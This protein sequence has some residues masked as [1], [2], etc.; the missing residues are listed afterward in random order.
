MA[1]STPTTCLTVQAS[2]R[3][4][5]VVNG[6]LPVVPASTEKLLTATAV[7]DQ[8]GP[9]ATVTTRAVAASG[10]TDGVV[11][12][13]LYVIGAGDP[14]LATK[15]YTST[16]EEP[17]EPYNDFAGL[18]DAL[19]SAGVTQI[20]GDVV[21]DESYFDTQRYLPSWP[22]RYISHNEVGPLGALMVNDGFTGLS[23]TP[24]VPA[25]NRR[26]G[27][28]AQLSAATLIS[29]LRERGIQVTGGPSV[30]TAPG[31]AVTVASLDS[32]PMSTNVSEM[33][34]RSDNTTA[35][36][37]AKLLGAHAGSGGTTEA[38][39]AVVHQSLQDL[40]FPL[41]G[42][43]EVDGSGLDL[44]NRVTCDLLVAALDHQG[45]DSTLA[46]DLPVAGRSGTLRKRLRGTVAE[47]DV[48]AKT[49][50]L[51]DVV[52]LA[53]FAKAADGE[54]LTFA[55]VMNGTLPANALTLSDDVAVAVAQYGTGIS[56]DQLG[57]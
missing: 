43:V 20:R 35:E 1:Q 5:A 27:D 24:E 41:D 45:P 13:N 46:G 19:K 32:K 40:G 8:L 57:P 4:V 51:N 3:P 28:P 16:F 49:G 17:D 34:R 39:V 9:D 33:L 30:G 36:V 11:D 23:A 2:G 38:G 14:I 56:L 29:L 47:G 15:G 10:A 18:A 44:G 42:A 37:L 53:G 54:Q 25:A 26:P 22:T 50:T 55:Y 48:R 31:G 7:L 12:G 21:G 6:R 52:A